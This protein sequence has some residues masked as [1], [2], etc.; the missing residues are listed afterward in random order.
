VLPAICLPHVARLRL[1]FGIL[2]GA[3]FASRIL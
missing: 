3:P 1:C 2:Y